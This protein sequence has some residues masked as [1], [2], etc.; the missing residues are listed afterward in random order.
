MLGPWANTQTRETLSVQT[1]A[2]LRH[3]FNYTSNWKVVKSSNKLLEIDALRSLSVN[4]FY[5]SARNLTHS[6]QEISWTIVLTHSHLEQP[7]QA[8]QFWWYFWNQSIFWKIFAGEIFIKHQTKTLLQIFCELFLHSKVIFKSMRVADD[9]FW[10]NSECE[11]VKD[12]QHGRSQQGVLVPFWTPK[13]LKRTPQDTQI[14][15]CRISK[16]VNLK[17]I[18]EFFQLLIIPMTLFNDI[19]PYFDE[20]IHVYSWNIWVCCDPP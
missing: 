12:L 6:C 2:N 19:M 14:F 7:K 13:P 20:S 18:I 15:L 3:T 8:G 10:R 11:W 17:L 1:E 16:N 5:D 9:T 4:E